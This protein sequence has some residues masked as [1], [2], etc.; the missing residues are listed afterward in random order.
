MGGCFAFIRSSALIAWMDVRLF[1]GLLPSTPKDYSVDYA[2]LQMMKAAS[3]LYTHTVSGLFVMGINRASF[4]ILN[5]KKEKVTM[6]AHVLL[7]PST[8]NSIGKCGRGSNKR[9]VPYLTLFP[10]SQFIFQLRPKLDGCH[11]RI[12]YSNIHYFPAQGGCR[13]RTFSG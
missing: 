11:R 12:L 6:L 5:M 1:Q 8:S 9:T 7:D 3:S 2:T 10:R 4:L 13:N